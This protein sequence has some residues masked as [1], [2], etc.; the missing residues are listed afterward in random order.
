VSFNSLNHKVF[1]TNLKEERR[2]VSWQK[3]ESQRLM[4]QQ[5]PKTKAK[6]SHAATAETKWMSLW[7]FLHWARKE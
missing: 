5:E 2:V 3:K 1:Y 7:L 6:D 4:L